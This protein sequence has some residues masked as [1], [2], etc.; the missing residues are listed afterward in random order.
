MK[1]I[2]TSDVCKKLNISKVT[3]WRW[4]HKGIF[5]QPKQYGLRAVGWLESEVD[6]WIDKNMSANY[7][8][9]EKMT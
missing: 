9:M 3:L 1:I 8:R 2:R 6:E 7:K 5:P 4:R